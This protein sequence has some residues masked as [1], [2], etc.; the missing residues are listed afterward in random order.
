MKVYNVKKWLTRLSDRLAYHPHYILKKYIDKIVIVYLN[1]I[2]IFNKALEK[3]KKYI[4][5]ILIILE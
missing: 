1:D 4:H 2:F 5:F 3:Y